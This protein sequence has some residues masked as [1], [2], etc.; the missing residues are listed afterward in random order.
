M[1]T[2]TPAAEI[3][4]DHYDVDIDDRGREHERCSDDDR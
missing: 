4:Y 3:H 1:A 2:T